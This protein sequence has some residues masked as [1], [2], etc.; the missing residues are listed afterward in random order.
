MFGFPISKLL[1]EGEEMLLVGSRRQ[2][3]IL[4]CVQSC[5]YPIIKY[6]FILDLKPV[7]CVLS[8]SLAVSVFPLVLVPN[9]ISRDL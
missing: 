3:C 9:K 1:S 7:Y 5:Y 4:P 6:N 8:L 2:K